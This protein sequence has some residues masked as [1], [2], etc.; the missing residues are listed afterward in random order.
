MHPPVWQAYRHAI[1][2][3]GPVPTLIEWDTDVPALDVLLDEAAL[4]TRIAAQTSRSAIR[5]MQ[6]SPEACW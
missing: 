3:L 2:R 5:P 4:A 6:R 1:A